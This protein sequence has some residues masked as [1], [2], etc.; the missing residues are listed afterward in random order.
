MIANFNAG[1]S[2]YAVALYNQKKVDTGEARI[3]YTQRLR[4][5]SPSV[6]NRAFELYNLS[7]GKKVALHVSLS[8]A[9]ADAPKL[10]DEQ[11]LSLTKEYLEKM[12]YAKQPYIVYRHMDTKHPHVHILTSRVDIETQKQI[13]DS[14]DRIRSKNI[15][16]KMERVYGLT[17]SDTQ[18]IVKE[19]I[20]VPIKRVLEIERPENLPQLNKALEKH[21][22]AARAEKTEKGL[23]YYRIGEG[24]I[25]NSKP[26]KASLYKDVQ[27]DQ[28]SLKVQFRQNAQA[29]FQ[30]KSAIQK[31]LPNQG[32]T[33]IGIFSKELQ[34]KGIYTDFKVNPDNSISIHYGYKGYI[35][36]DVNLNTTAQ[37]Q[38][39]FP[40]PQDLHL[41]E[42]IKRSIAANQPL[43]LSYQNGKLIV[44]SPDKELEQNLNKRS[45]REILAITDLHNNHKEQY[46][47]TDTIN[48]RNAI[49]ALA[50]SDIDETLQ[51]KINRERIDQRKIKR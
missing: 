18:R 35:Y 15:T 37:Q 40:E 29:R 36:K 38:L 19:E 39:V 2:F 22:I 20:T 43:E 34:A 4:G 48:A 51:E 45:D 16:D 17:I 13:N 46:Q 27:L 11:M 1:N 42:Q 30:V 7:I 44:Q 24:G 5:T 6:V 23:I 3:L 41:R 26:Y 32:K 21:Q 25:R 50:A 31:A 47:K 49:L 33:T 14:F 12:G 28:D 9:E 8:F 10:D